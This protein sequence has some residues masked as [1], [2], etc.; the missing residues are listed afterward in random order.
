MN[1]VTKN[2]IPN[3]E[4]LIKFDNKKIGSIT[5]SN[6]HYLFLRKGKSTEIEDIEYLRVTLNLKLE[7]YNNTNNTA[8]SGYFIYDY[9]C[10]TKP[11][12]PV[13]NIKKK[14]PIYL[15]SE[16]SKSQFCAGYYVIKFNK[17]WVK[18][19]CPKLLTLDRHEFKGPFKDEEEV[20]ALLSTLNK[21]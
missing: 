4:W 2:V 16:N 10:R 20:K 18:S 13:Y 17:G 9:P 21:T 6:K 15:K 8:A 19:F 3:K 11:Y 5:K 12:G 14:L 1:T 7:S